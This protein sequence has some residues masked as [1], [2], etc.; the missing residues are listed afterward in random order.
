MRTVGPNPKGPVSCILDDKL[1]YSL[2]LYTMFRDEEIRTTASALILVIKQE[3][4]VGDPVAVKMEAEIDAG[5]MRV[6]SAQRSKVHKMNLFLICW[7]R[8]I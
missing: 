1:N 3:A 2:V 6:E 5:F 7:A 4:L 8:Q